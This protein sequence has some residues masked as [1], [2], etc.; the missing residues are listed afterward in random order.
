MTALAFYIVV[1]VAA[2]ALLAAHLAFWTWFYRR[3]CDPD[4]RHYVRTADGWTVAVARVR[5]ADGPADGAPVLCCPGLACNAKLF[6][7]TPRL[8]LARH[9]AACGF[10]VWML[11]PRGTGES[12]RAGLSAR[13]WRYGFDEYVRH[14]A[15]AAV[16]HIRRVTG[17]ESLHW[18]GHSMGGLIGIHLAARHPQG[19]ALAGIVM[20]GSPIDLSGHKKHVGLPIHM[21]D[22]WMRGWPVVR[23]GQVCRFVAPLSGWARGFIE[24][25]FMNPRLMSVAALRGF[26]ANVVED[27]PRRLLDQFADGVFRDRG[28]D[29]KP[30]AEERAILGR[31]GR[32]L[33][34]VAG[35]RDHIAPVSACAVDG[36][37]PGSHDCTALVLGHDAADAAFGHID[38]ILGEDAPRQ[39]YPRVADWLLARVSTRSSSAAGSDPEARASD[40]SDSQPG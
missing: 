32:P 39:V 34:S 19:E 28:F 38:L 36:R 15:A 23:L 2:F 17:R 4:E 31:Y 8:S 33:Y 35:A 20:V 21:L 6:D 22:W 18:I 3:R 24:P 1:P 25:L 37:F 40:S 16:E 5:A 7:L 30:L 12:E 26:L 10:D 9:L 13:R 14:D 27:V 11:D 29:G